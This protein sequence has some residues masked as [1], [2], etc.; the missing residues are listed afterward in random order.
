MFFLLFFFISNFMTQ[1]PSYKF[2]KTERYN[3]G[4]KTHRFNI[5]IYVTEDFFEQGKKTQ[6]EIIWRAENDY[7]IKQES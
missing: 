3:K 2:H 1:Q 6:Y 7:Y 5:I 4:I